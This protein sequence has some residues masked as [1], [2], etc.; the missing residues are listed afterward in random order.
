MRRGQGGARGARDGGGSRCGGA[1]G[2]P[3][4]GTTTA[5]GTTRADD[6]RRRGDARGRPG[7][8]RTEGGG[9]GA[10]GNVARG[11]RSR[12]STRRAARVA[13]AVHARCDA[14]SA[15]RPT[16]RRFGSSASSVGRPLLYHSAIAVYRLGLC[17]RFASWMG[18]AKQGR[19]DERLGARTRH[20]VRM[21]ISQN[22]TTHP[23][24]RGLKSRV[25]VS[26]PP[27][28]SDRPRPGSGRFDG[29]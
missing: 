23:R 27:C 5:V 16:T 10:S 17:H 14:P 4:R 15:G 26:E 3:R 21:R 13:D 19:S 22:L 2:T 20:M 11:L 12:R 6:A 9:H 7:G 28:I 18:E 29:S 24:N 25:F 1:D 8:R